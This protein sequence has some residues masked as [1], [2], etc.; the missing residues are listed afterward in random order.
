MYELDDTIAAVSSPTS[1]YRV[2]LRI[3]GPH[4]FEKTAEI[5]SGCTFDKA[6][7]FTGELAV[8][9]ELKI[10]AKVYVFL[11]PHSYTGERL[12]EIHADSNASVTEALTGTLLASGVRM[13]GPGEFTARAYLNGKMDLSQAEAVN[14]IVTSSNE[15]QLAAAEKVLSGRLAQTTAQLREQMMDILSLIEVGLD[16]SGEDIEFLTRPEG[17]KHLATIRQ[18]LEQLLSGSIS[19]ETVMDLPAVGI[20]GAP[21]AGKSSLLNELVGTDRSIVSAERKTTRDVLT[22]VATLEHCRTVFFDCAGL[23]QEPNGILE[24]LSQQAA[25]EGLQNA[26]AAVFCVDVSKDEWTEDAAIRNLIQPKALIPVATKTDLPSREVLAAR[27]D[28]LGRTFAV[29]F[30]PTSSK[31][32]VGVQQLRNKIDQKII[33]AAGSAGES[34]ALPSSVAITARHKQ[35][36]TEALESV[37]ES[38]KEWE[39]GN[40]EVAAMMLRAAYQAVAN[41]EA[42]HIDEKILERIFSRFC[43]GK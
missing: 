15:L 10:N 7:I 19:Y 24:R 8:D 38:V 29:D 30:L 12:V 43:I 4:A 2:I 33:E 39:A 14:E 20:A 34:G 5:F 16:F 25:I 18:A 37:N 40:D 27:L 13:A 28:A 36:I 26:T 3:T 6:G 31:T 11:P 17:L 22:A 21:N 9:N 41:I 23:L 1:D 35:A 42:E 32:G